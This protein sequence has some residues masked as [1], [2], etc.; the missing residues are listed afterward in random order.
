MDTVRV[1]R[2]IKAFRKLKGFTQ[3]DFAKELKVSITELRSVERGVRE[4]HDVFLDQVA[5]T[6]AVPKEELI[7]KNEHLKEVE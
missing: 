1:G 5:V 4:A 6:L 7:G 3:I 2:R